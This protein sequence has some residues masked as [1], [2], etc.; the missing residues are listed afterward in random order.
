MIV[1]NCTAVR[2]DCLIKV[3]T[4]SVTGESGYPD[5]AAV[6]RIFW[7]KTYLSN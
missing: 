2:S 6:F 3:L 4:S 7:F 1:A 5:F